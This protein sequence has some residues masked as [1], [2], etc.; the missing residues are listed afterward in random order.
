[1]HCALP[2]PQRCTWSP[3][4][5]CVWAACRTY[6]LP[7]PPVPV[8]PRA[9]LRVSFCLPPFLP[10]LPTPF[11][12]LPPCTRSAAR[13]LL[14]CPLSAPG[15]HFSRLG[16]LS[17]PSCAPHRRASHIVTVTV[18]QSPT[19]PPRTAH[20]IPRTTP[21]TRSPPYAH[22]RT[23]M[24]RW[25]TTRR[26]AADD[27]AGAGTDGDVDE[28]VHCLLADLGADVLVR[29]DATTYGPTG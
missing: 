23:G 7:G 6:M 17:A 16:F 26:T 3:Q 27:E 8:A 21:P 12:P 14:S 13:P 4:L 11:C 22:R 19:H 2:P 25:W 28:H 20:Y 15:L 10:P 5:Y 24:R 9:R 18:S 29:I 1:M